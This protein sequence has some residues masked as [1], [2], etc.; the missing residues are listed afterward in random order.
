MAEPN[1]KIAKSRP[2]IPAGDDIAK[3]DVGNVP[4]LPDPDDIQYLNNL[5]AM[6]GSGDTDNFDI[7]LK[8]MDSPV[9][10]DSY[11]SKIDKGPAPLT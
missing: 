6:P 1:P 7:D 10:H 5:N 11:T 4:A 3:F 2:S 8:I 9:P